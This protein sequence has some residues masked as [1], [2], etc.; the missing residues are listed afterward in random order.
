MASY[1]G[2]IETGS[3]TN[4]PIGSTLYGICST[5]ATAAEKIVVLPEFDTLLTGTTIH[6]KFTNGNTAVGP[7]L[8][9]GSTAAK[10]I[11]IYG[12]VAPGSTSASTWAANSVLSLTYDGTAWRMNDVGF[13]MWDSIYPV[14]SIYMSV[15]STN[16]GTL[17]GGTWEQIKDRFLL[18]AGTTYTA[19][20]TGGAATVSLTEEN[21]P[22]HRHSIPA[23]SGTAASKSI[24]HTHG[25]GSGSA[26]TMAP[27]GAWSV[28]IISGGDGTKAPGCDSDKSFS[29]ASSTAS[30]GGSHDH[31]VTTT[32]SN[33]GYLGSG[34]AVDKMP[35]YLA[36][37]I[38]KRTA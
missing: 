24:A 31:S 38:W 21:I 28:K 12:T 11:Y 4:S 25:V 26:F 18:S 32:A 35:P 20:T 6:V 17:F 1:A 8:T 10:P 23:L 13:A 7:T 22:S 16:P 29:Y 30:G 34:T 19:G 5:A 27:S 3:G 9:V 33:T 14:G 36:V 2:Q 37:Y 15:N